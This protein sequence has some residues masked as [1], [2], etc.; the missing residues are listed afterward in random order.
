MT[1]QRVPI[2][3]ETGN[4]KTGQF[5]LDLELEPP[6]RAVAWYEQLRLQRLEVVERPLQLFLGRVRQM[7]A[8]HDGVQ[9]GASAQF[10]RVP[11][12]IH[13]AGVAAAREHD[14]SLVWIRPDRRQL[15][16][17]PTAQPPLGYYTDENTYPSD[18]T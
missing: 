5:L 8:A 12:R 13:H 11:R 7:E 18:Y 16:D 10:D 4:Q 3:A 14:Q 2:P 6:A 15:S 1:S 17:V 9:R